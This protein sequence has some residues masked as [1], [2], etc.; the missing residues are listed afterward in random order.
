LKIFSLRDLLK[1]DNNLKRKNSD[2][3]LNDL[4]KEQKKICN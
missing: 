4:I 3:E 2:E 1:N